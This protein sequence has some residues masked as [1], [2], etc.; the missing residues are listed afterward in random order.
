MYTLTLTHAERR[1][2]DFVGD[3]YATGENFATLLW[4]QSETIG[5]E[6]DEPGDITFHV[7]EHIAWQLAQLSDEEEGRFPLFARALRNKLTDFLSKI[8]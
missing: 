5:P 3:R 8:V 7:P 6:W 4:E 2:F 1:A